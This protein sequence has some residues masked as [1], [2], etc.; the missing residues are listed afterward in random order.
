MVVKSDDLFVLISAAFVM[1]M[2][3]GV[4]IFYGGMVSSK[5]VLSLL[6]QSLGILGIISLQW[7]FFGYTLAFGPDIGGVIGSLKYLFLSGISGSSQ[8]GSIHQMTFVIFQMMFAVI[9]PALI[10]GAFVERVKFLPTMLF[11]LLWSSFVYDPVAH[12][13]WGGG[14]IQKLGGLDFAGGAVIHINAGVAALVGALY[15]GRRDG[16]NKRAFTFHN[17]PFVVLGAAMLWFGWFGFNSGSALSLSFQALSAFIN[18]H[19]AASSALVAWGTAEYIGRGKPTVLGMASGAVAGLAAI[20]PASGYV[21]PLGAILIGAAAGFLCYHAT[22]LRNKIGYDDSLDVFSVHGIGSITGMLAL[23]F[24]A[25]KHVG[26][27]SG[28]IHQVLLQLITIVA[29]ALYSG[30]ISFILYFL[31][32]KLVGFRVEPDEEKQGIDIVE[33]GE[34]A[35]DM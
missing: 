27:V 33:H 32:D 9:T 8:I 25:V 5:N 15:I 7:F 2:T 10:I 1:L 11:C 18:T 14:W 23:G 21:S 22:I 16:F 4:A 20:T 13:V 31:V 35:Y 24:L 19:L 26:G 17:I 34:R 12:W 30:A 29:V 3:P 6:G 28:S